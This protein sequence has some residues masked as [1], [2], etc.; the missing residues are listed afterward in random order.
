MSL[1]TEKGISDLYSFMPGAMG[2][3]DFHKMPPISKSGE[4]TRH[5]SHLWAVFYSK[6]FAKFY[7]LFSYQSEISMISF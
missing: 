7:R 1:P 3:A 5:S 4:V 6:N 2:F